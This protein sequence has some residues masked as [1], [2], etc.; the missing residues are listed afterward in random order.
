MAAE[1]F[2]SVSSELKKSSLTERRSY[3]VQYFQ[4]AR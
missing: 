4:N 2:G 3:V 1:F